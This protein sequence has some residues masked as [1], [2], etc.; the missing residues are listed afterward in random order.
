MFYRGIRAI[1]IGVLTIFFS[2]IFG[3]HMRVKREIENGDA[4]FTT[5]DCHYVM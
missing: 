3:S 4:A 1:I 5:S 2:I